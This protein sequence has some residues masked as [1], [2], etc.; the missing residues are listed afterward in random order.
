MRYFVVQIHYNGND[1]SEL[2]FVGWIYGT[3]AVLDKQ[4]V[5]LHCCVRLNLNVLLLAFDPVCYEVV[6][7]SACDILL[8]N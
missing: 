8:S 5:R 1:D 2:I 7:S 6:I 4:S 3:G